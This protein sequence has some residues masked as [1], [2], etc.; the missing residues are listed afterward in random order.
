MHG[1]GPIDDSTAQMNTLEPT[2]YDLGGAC[3]P[4]STRT[5][6]LIALSHG[7]HVMLTASISVSQEPVLRC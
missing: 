5:K 4:A 2:S 1:Q 3:D 6:L 7:V